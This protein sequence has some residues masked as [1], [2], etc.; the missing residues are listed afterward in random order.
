MTV[1]ID[2]S[3]AV[4]ALIGG[5]KEG[6]WAEDVIARGSLVA[7]ALI[8]VESANV[9]RRLEQRKGLSS[10]EI[11]GA[12]QDLLRLDVE[13]FPYE[14]FA[15]RIWG[16]RHNVSSYD[17]WYVAVAESLNS[18]LATLDHR[19]LGASGPSCRFLVPEREA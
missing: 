8:I 7:P 1:V 14:P 15:S 5:G 9:L 11:N 16:L 10:L 6:Q 17:A 4:S 18:D 12:Y 3:V 13:L 2:A 19:L